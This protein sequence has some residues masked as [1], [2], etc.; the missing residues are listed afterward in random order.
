MY[1]KLAESRCALPHL[2]KRSDTPTDCQRRIQPR[3]SFDNAQYTTHPARE[4]RKLYVASRS[5]PLVMSLALRPPASSSTPPPQHLALHQNTTK[6]PPSP[7][8]AYRKLLPPLNA[9]AMMPRFDPFSAFPPRF[10]CRRPSTPP[11]FAVLRSE[12]NV[13]LQLPIACTLHSF[14]AFSICLGV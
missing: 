8:K 2:T 12:L 13:Y 5:P 14:P 1:C 4:S 11:A 10:A 3:N 9:E 7:D 6:I